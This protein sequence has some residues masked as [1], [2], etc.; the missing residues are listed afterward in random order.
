MLL[1]SAVIPL[2]LWARPQGHGETHEV[3]V[4]R[5]PRPLPYACPYPQ[6]VNSTMRVL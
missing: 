2:R 5:R 1:V 4:L 6:A 3:F